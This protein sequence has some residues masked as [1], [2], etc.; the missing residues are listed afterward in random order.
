MVRAK[1]LG[2]RSIS[3]D[4]FGFITSKMY[5]A[6]PEK[7]SNSSLTYYL[8]DLVR[9]LKANF[10]KCRQD[11][12]YQSI[13]ESMTNFKGR[14]TLK[15][16]MPFKLV[17]RGIKI[18][19]RCNAST[20]YTYDFN[21]YSGKE[22]ELSVGTLGERVV[23]KLASSIIEPD[24]TLC[25]DRFFTSVHLV[26]TISFSAVGTVMSNRKNLPVFVKN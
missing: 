25:F 15:Q 18:W 20:G 24:V 2:N 23:N 4:R 7:P 14:S 13:G 8:D 26:E 6:T 3:R 16:Y 9:C 17:K 21:I 12:S 10:Q 1:S 11:S 5:F 22:M 19:L